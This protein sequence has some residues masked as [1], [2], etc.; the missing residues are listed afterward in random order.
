MLPL[1]ENPACLCFVSHEATKKA[2][3]DK[4]M[5]E[6]ADKQS[7]LDDDVEKISTKMEQMDAESATLKREA[8]P[9]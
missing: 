4:E 7:D 1:P 9:Q 3:C 2:W 6:T 5:G 8:L